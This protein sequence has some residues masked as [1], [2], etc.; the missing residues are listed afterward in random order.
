MQFTYNRFIVI[1][2]E[3]PLYLYCGL[4]FPSVSV[5]LFVCLFFSISRQLST[6]VMIHLLKPRGSCR[7]T[8]EE[9]FQSIALYC[10]ACFFKFIERR[11]TFIHDTCKSDICIYILT[12][13]FTSLYVKGKSLD[14]LSITTHYVS[15][16][17]RSSQR[18]AQ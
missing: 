14:I 5:S 3:I 9:S 7:F 11:M 16:Q 13:S 8:L 18:V 10:P 6:A 12:N 1:K 15:Y 17:G 4:I 2:R